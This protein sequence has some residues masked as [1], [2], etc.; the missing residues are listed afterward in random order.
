ML[1]EQAAALFAAA[2]A[3]AADDD[4][5][6]SAP[7]SAAAA[8]AA[9][10]LDA[11]ALVADA[12]PAPALEASSDPTTASPPPPT[13]E[14][15][16]RALSL[17]RASSLNCYSYDSAAADSL[18][19]RASLL[20]QSIGGGVDPCTWRIIIRNVTTLEPPARRAEGLAMAEELA[21]SYQLLDALL[22]EAA[23]GRPG[24]LG[25]ARAQAGQTL[26]IERGI[27]GFVRGVLK[28]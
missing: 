5:P 15:I 13:K 26:E 3:L 11:A 6:S 12:G 2:P 18:E 9:R 24:A 17:V 20:Q 10:D 23:D 22:T 28:V 4:A 8:A 19:A 14:D 25:R 27:E 7:S 1:L 21:R 16:A